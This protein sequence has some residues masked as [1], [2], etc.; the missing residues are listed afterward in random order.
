[1]TRPVV[2]AQTE[3]LIA[4]RRLVVT[5]LIGRGVTQREIITALTEKGYTNP[6]TMEPWS[7]GTINADVKAIRAEMRRQ[8]AEEVADVRSRLLLELRE[9]R[10]QA[11]AD[12]NLPEV[13]LG[14]KQEAELLG[15][16]VPVEQ[17]LTHK[18]GAPARVVTIYMDPPTEQAETDGP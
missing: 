8:V 15:V 6:E 3:A 7:L 11:W 13:R 18:G 14:I 17:V 4:Q 5:Q 12:K 10:R 16:N 9:H 1:M 2:D